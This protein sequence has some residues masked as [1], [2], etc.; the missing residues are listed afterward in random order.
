M[1]SEKLVGVEIGAESIQA[2]FEK[3]NETFLS[4]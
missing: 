1:T 2:W 4:L 3:K